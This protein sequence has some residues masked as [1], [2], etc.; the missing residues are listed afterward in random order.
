[1]FPYAIRI[2]VI[3]R[4]EHKTLHFA[5]I[6]EISHYNV[7]ELVNT[8]WFKHFLFES[9]A[10]GCSNRRTMFKRYLLLGMTML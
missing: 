10:Q 8:F 7:L 3:I 2:H 9:F 5:Q 6:G 4:T 1:M